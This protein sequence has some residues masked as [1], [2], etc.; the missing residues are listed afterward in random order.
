MHT[1][2]CDQ[3][4]KNGMYKSGY[5]LSHT[6]LFKV[7]VVKIHQGNHLGFEKKSACPISACNIL[8]FQK[9][10]SQWE[11]TGC[12]D[13]FIECFFMLLEPVTFVLVLLPYMTTL[14]HEHELKPKFV[15]VV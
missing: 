9:G 7:E 11:H 8:K 2:I 6:R 10:I 4:C 12:Q 5:A 14:C 1:C 3:F 13:N 15:L